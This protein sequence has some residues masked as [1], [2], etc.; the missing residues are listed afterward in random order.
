MN[1][2]ELF[3]NANALNANVVVNVIVVILSELLAVV[4]IRW[5]LLFVGEEA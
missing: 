5:Q 2:F 3:S 1:L 4:R